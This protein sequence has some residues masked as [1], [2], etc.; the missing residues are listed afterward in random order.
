MVNFGGKP[1]KS[2]KAP[3]GDTTISQ[4]PKSILS[5]D[6]CKIQCSNAKET[7]TIFSKKFIESATGEEKA[8]HHN[9]RIVLF[10]TEMCRS[11][12][13]LGYCKYGDRCQFCHS[14]EELRN[15]H[16]H[17]KYKTEICK[18]FWNDGSCPYG[19][20][21]CFIHLEND[22]KKAANNRNFAE[23][24]LI[25]SS[26]EDES[27]EMYSLRKRDFANLGENCKFAGY[28]NSCQLNIPETSLSMID[29]ALSSSKHLLDFDVITNPINDDSGAFSK[30]FD[31]TRLADTH[32][33]KSVFEL[34]NCNSFGSSENF[35]SEVAESSITH[36][37]KEACPTKAY[38]N[39]GFSIF[40][41]NKAILHSLIL[42]SLLKEER[43]S[44][45]LNKYLTK[46]K[47][48]T[49]Q[50][51]KSQESEF[52]KIRKTA[53]Q[54]EEDESSK[55][56]DLSKYQPANVNSIENI[57]C[58]DDMSLKKFVR[59]RKLEAMEVMPI[60]KDRCFINI[61][62]ISIQGHSSILNRNLISKW[63]SDPIFFIIFDK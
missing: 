58:V 42:K 21:C 28:T 43:N 54:Q 55:E 46:I 1:K 12:N 15:V 37:K 41:K 59:A 8:F 47:K 50:I 52:N 57:K 27:S 48:A 13:E 44:I 62:E 35:N 30:P 10:K 25:L 17:P 3:Q 39:T 26:K 56:S 60:K 11:Y 20:R 9:K 63:K 53:D 2:T 18:T 40:S 4:G 34:K 5:L 22:L 61:E 36:I 38:S 32:Q 33:T 24:S 45:D 7:K 31:T 23:K 16:R 29:K 49:D 19:S 6:L 14:E 51:S